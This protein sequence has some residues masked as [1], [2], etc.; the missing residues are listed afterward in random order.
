MHRTLFKTDN[1][2]GSR[3]DKEHTMLESNIRSVLR[4]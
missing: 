4:G 2:K 3:Q 1:D